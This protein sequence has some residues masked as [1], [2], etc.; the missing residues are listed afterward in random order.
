M[1]LKSHNELQ[2]ANESHVMTPLHSSHWFYLIFNFPT[3]TFSRPAYVFKMNA[4]ECRYKLNSSGQN[5]NKLTL[6]VIWTITSS[7][8]NFV[9]RVNDC[10]D[11]RPRYWVWKKH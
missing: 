7:M 4:A 11:C 2:E 10:V 1:L 5:T 9:P 6:Y 3:I 8:C